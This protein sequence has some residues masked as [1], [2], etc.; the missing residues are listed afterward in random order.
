MSAEYLW[1]PS[2]GYS[3]FQAYGVWRVWQRHIG[4]KYIV[5]ELIPDAA[6]NAKVKGIKARRFNRFFLAKREH[7]KRDGG[8]PCERDLAIR[9]MDSP[10][11]EE[12]E[13]IYQ[14]LLTS[15]WAHEF[16]R[17]DDFSR[18]VHTSILRDILRGEYLK[19]ERTWRRRDLGPWA[20]DLF[21]RRHPSAKA[22]AEMDGVTQ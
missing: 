17:R 20:E 5:V 12:G 11:G 9:E 1:T 19:R 15:Q 22:M 13:A 4:R 8:E 10:M 14:W 6:E 16:G 7:L 18:M 2:D 3:S 21:Q